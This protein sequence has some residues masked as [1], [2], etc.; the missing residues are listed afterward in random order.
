MR[1]SVSVLAACAA[2]AASLAREAPACAADG[3][4]AY[5]RLDGD[6]LLIGEAG[7]AYVDGAPG[8]LLG[9]RALYL[10]TAGFY[11]RYVDTF[12]QH[13]VAAARQIGAGVELRPLFLARLPAPGRMRMCRMMTSFVLTPRP[14]LMRVMP[15]L[16]AVSP[17]M[18]TWEFEIFSE[19]PPRSITPAT[20]N[21]ITRGPLAAMASA[22]EP[23]P[24]DAS[25]VTRMT[26]PSAPPLVVV[27]PGGDSHG[28]PAS[29]AA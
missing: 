22:N 23:A 8:L 27:Q 25:V 16:G 12:E 7:V 18:V 24:L 29:G 17:A 21:S 13:E 6:V 20:A 14:P 9:G 3:D 1:L 15:G 4:G 19:R 2:L 5:G 11:A 26:L 28:D 10:S